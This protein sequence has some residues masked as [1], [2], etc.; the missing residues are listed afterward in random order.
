MFR[1]IFKSKNA[2]CLIGSRTGG[3]KNSR[4]AAAILKHIDQLHLVL[5][6]D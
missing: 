1:I 3:N 6:E 4:N 5:K 2:S